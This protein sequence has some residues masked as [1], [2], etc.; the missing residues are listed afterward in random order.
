M[1]ARTPLTV[2]TAPFL[3]SA[4]VLGSV[5]RGRSARETYTATASIKTAGAALTT[6]VAIDVTAW[7]SEVDRKRLAG[8]LKSGG[9]AALEKQLAAMETLRGDYGREDGIRREIRLRDGQ[10]GRPHHHRRH[11][12]RRCSSSA[13]APPVPHPKTAT[14]LAS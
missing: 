6:P 13:P 2:N 1:A 9:D 4:L 11:D 12:V 10:L 14:S 8:V 5:D 3:V 7:T